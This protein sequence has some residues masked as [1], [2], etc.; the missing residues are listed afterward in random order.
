[1][2]SVIITFM[3]RFYTGKGDDGYTGLLGEGRIPKYHPN[4]GSPRSFG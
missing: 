1:M 2:L 3:T 4:N